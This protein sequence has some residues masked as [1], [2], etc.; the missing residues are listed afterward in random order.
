MK[1]SSLPHKES[2][3][4]DPNKPLKLPTSQ[5]WKEMTGRQSS[6]RIREIIIRFQQNKRCL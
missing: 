3:K 5:K 4:D 2:T 1:D 6:D